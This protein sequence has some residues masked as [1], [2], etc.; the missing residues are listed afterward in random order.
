MGL[1]QDMFPW[2]NIHELNLDWILS[3]LRALSIKLDEFVSLNS[4]KYADPIQWN[5]STQYAKNTVV[6]DPNTGTAYLS[7]NPVPSGVLLT[8]TDYWTP[9]FELYLLSGNKNITLRDDGINPAATFESVPGDWILWNYTLYK[10]IDHNID[11]G[12]VYTVDYNLSRYT[13]EMFLKEYIQNTIN[14]IDGL[15]GNLSD[16]STADKTN[17]VAAINELYDNIGVLTNLH[18]ADNSS[19]VNAIN[20]IYDILVIARGSWICPEDFGAVGDG[21]TDDTQHLQDMFNWMHDR[22]GANIVAYFQHNYLVTHIEITGNTNQTIHADGY[23]ITG[24]ATD[25]QESV[26][27]IHPNNAEYYDLTVTANH[28]DNYKSAIK[29]APKVENGVVTCPAT[30]STFYSMEVQGAIIGLMIGEDIGETSTPAQVSENTFIGFKNYSCMI[31]LYINQLG[32]YLN[33]IGGVFSANRGEWISIYP[34]NVYDPALSC[35]IRCDVGEV[36]ITAAEIIKTDF[37]TGAGLWGQGIQISQCNLEV[38]SQWI[39]A[40]GDIDIDTINNGYN[41]GNQPLIAT[42]GNDVLGQCTI[43]NVVFR[44]TTNISNFLAYCAG[45]P[46]YKVILENVYISGR[47]YDSRFIY[48]CDFELKNVNYLPNGHWG[49]EAEYPN[50]FGTD[51]IQFLNPIAAVDNPRDC[52]DITIGGNI[53]K[54]KFT[55]SNNSGSSATIIEQAYSNPANN[56]LKGS[57]RFDSANGSNNIVF[58]LDAFEGE[59]YS[60]STLIA[61]LLLSSAEITLKYL[62]INGSIIQSVLL[63]TISTADAN[64]HRYNE[65]FKI[66]NGVYGMLIVI[67]ASSN[68]IQVTDLKIRKY[69]A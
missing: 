1:F 3:R 54:A 37:P 22:D 53:T 40:S 34:S 52:T 23:R 27:T 58:T 10:V 68:I 43:R 48:G 64:M 56:T 25:P 61:N 17:L 8:N 50:S 5:I 38:A 28:K 41:G 63:E 67:T 35:C 15:T 66:P 30:Y 19:L 29:I 59:V 55:L 16:L 18:T 9:I 7:T 69:I 11:I 46:F 42:I 31:P 47:P 51:A 36:L 39:Y 62:D 26:V 57:Y 21:V 49:E 60:I 20:E 4:I 12:D 65:L 2:T 14:Y 44:T 24:I 13:V 33:F 6:I 45:S 32:G